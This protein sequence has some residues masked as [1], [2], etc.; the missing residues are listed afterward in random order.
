VLEANSGLSAA[1]AIDL[2]DGSGGGT[3]FNLAES[4]FASIQYVKVEGLPG[5]D[6]GQ[7]DA[8]ASVR[9]MVLG[10]SLTIA[11]ANLT[12]GTGTLRFQ[13]PG[14]LTET[15]LALAFTAVSDVGRVST[16]PLPD[17]STLAPVSGQVL[18]AAGLGFSAVLGSGVVTFQADLRVSAGAGYA[19]NGADLDLLCWQGTNWQRVAFAYQ[20]SSNTVVATGVTNLSSVALVQVQPP[21]LTLVLHGSETDVRFVPVAG[22][23]HTLERTTGFNGWSRVACIT[24]TNG[25]LLAL[26]DPNPP[27]DH[28][29][30]RVRLTR[31]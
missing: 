13:Q 3:G 5:L 17:P 26:S 7:V 18:T 31:P 16:A 2:F 21:R 12:S 20:A 24:P 30:Y 15:A 27:A 19:G 8:L 11:P 14:S 6:G 23:M 9:P 28:A 22:W 25:Q 10:D 29:F 1:D 4:G